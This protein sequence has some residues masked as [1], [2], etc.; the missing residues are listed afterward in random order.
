MKKIKIL[1]FKTLIHS[2]CIF[3]TFSSCVSFQ[4]NENILE[5]SSKETPHW[6]SETWQNHFSNE[7]IYLVY[8]K[9]D[10]YNLHLGLKQAQAAASLQT[11]YLIMHKIQ[12]DLLNKLTTSS[13]ANKKKYES[14]II[15]LSHAIRENRLSIHPQPAT[16]KDIYWEYRQRDTDNGPERFYI[17]WV[18]LTVPKLDYESAL[19]HTARNLIK[20]EQKDI[21][22]LGQNILQ[23]M[24]PR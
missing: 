12:S 19:L 8:K 24:S 15:E 17:V 1:Y 5:K 4:D 21:V 2:I 20:S 13:T 11:S 14:I 3:I 6:T 10:I 22:D 18:L 9:S 23:Q 7:Y 16:P